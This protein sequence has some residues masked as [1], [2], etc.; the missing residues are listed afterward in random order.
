M[1]PR[2]PLDLVA[3][4][5]AP[6]LGLYGGADPGIPMADVE[7]MRDALKAAGKPS[8]IV[9]YDGAPHGFHADYRPSYRPEPAKDGWQ[10]LQAWFTKNGAA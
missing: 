9:V 8:E 2:H 1:R 10:R 5:K 3:D 7:K 6:V 4:L